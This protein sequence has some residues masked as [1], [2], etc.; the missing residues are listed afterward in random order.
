MQFLNDADAFG[1]GEWWTGR[2]R[3]ARRIVAATLGTGFGSAFLAD[4]R[5]VHG[6][7]IPPGGEIYR[8]STAVHRSRR[9]SRG[10]R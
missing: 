1:L 4:G 5:V 6:P 2:Q 9:R 8:I 10:P 7:G 3:G